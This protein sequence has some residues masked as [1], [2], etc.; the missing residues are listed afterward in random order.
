LE[1]DELERRY[2]QATDPVTRSQWQILWLVAQGHS[3]QQIIASTG[4]SKTWICTI[5]QRY[6]TDGPDRVGDRR[7][8]NPGAVALLSDAQLTELEKALDGPAPDGGIWSG[9]KV[10]KWMAD[11]LGRKIHLQRGWEVLVRLGYRSY[12]PRP[13]HAK[14]NA[15]AQ[16]Q[17]QK[18]RFHKL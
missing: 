14:A 18:K 8:T 1:R 10:A 17:F 16:E 9:P 2:R 7:H 15:A 6:N 11:K 12:V 3:T 13:Q 5:V 4:Y